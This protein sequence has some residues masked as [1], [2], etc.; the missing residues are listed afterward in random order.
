MGHALFISS[1]VM[2]KI[3]FAL[4]SVCC[5]AAHAQYS[6]VSSG[7]IIDI[8]GVKAIVFNVDDSGEHGTAMTINCLR[9]VKEFWCTDNKLSKSMPMTKDK[10]NGLANTQAVIDFA[11]TKNALD[12]FPIFNWCNKLGE[13]W[14]VPS[15]KE[16]ETFV[17]FWLGNEQTE[18]W[19]ADDE[20]E[21]V[22]DDSKPYY[23]QINA[24]II[25]A[26]GVPFLN[27]AISSTLADNGSVYAFYFDRQKNSWSF[28]KMSK[29]SYLSKYLVGRAF[30]KF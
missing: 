18:D 21:N 7:D 17:N 28:K 29:T 30:Y 2:K 16:L 13:G 9:G 15:V 3:I 12:K 22:I 14:Y 19:D 20:T 27:G 26:G 10:E 24:K 6:N 4:L 5:I 8:N 23:K 1:N 11:S 25:E